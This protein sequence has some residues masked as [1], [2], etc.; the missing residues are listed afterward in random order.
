MDNASAE[1]TAV[2]NDPNQRVED[3]AYSAAYNF[4]IRIRVGV[5]RIWPWLRLVL[6]LC[7]AF[8]IVQI[9]DG[10]FQTVVISMLGL[11]YCAV[12][13]VRGEATDNAYYSGFLATFTTSRLLRYIM[14]EPNRPLE[15]KLKEMSEDTETASAPEGR[16]RRIESGLLQVI[17]AVPLLNVFFAQFLD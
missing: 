10:A 2:G 8:T 11:I 13:S 6:R 15:D 3:A 4:V 14:S 1:Q 17:F 16:L 5:A 7:V 12:L 9:G